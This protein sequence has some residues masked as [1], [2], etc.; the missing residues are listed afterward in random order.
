MEAK[1][2]WAAMLFV[3][4]LGLATVVSR[5]AG[6]NRT[7]ERD[8]ARMRAAVDPKVAR[9]IYTSD[10]IVGL[11]APVMRYFKFALVPGQSLIRRA[12]VTQYGTFARSPNAW[13]PFTATEDFAV[14]PPGFVWDARI[15]M[16]PLIWTRVRDSYVTGTGAIRASVA[17][18]VTVVNETGTPEMAS[19]ALLR[20]L[21]ESVWLP[22]ALLP[23]QGVTWTAIDNASARATRTD[24]Q[25]T[26]SMDV[27][28][29]SNGEISKIV[30]MRYRD[31]DGALVL[32]PWEGRF[33]DYERVNGMRVPHWGEVGWQLPDGWFSYW[34]GTN[35]R[36]LFEFDSVATPSRP[37]R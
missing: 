30:G 26:V 23:S 15:R 16:A 19:S 7:T 14:S 10:E 11:P 4:T 31:V 5:I 37:E 17:G 3:A 20:H 1:T 18:L 12:R 6:W 35:D 9:G 24:G 36:W 33:S 29:A 32:T 21:A 27:Y 8:I 28:F 25:T 13:E 22:T 34:R 2:V